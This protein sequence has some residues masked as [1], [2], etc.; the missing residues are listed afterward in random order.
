MKRILHTFLNYFYRL[1]YR[2]LYLYR[3]I[4]IAK[5]V[6]FDRNTTFK[7]NIKIY[8]NV[9]IKNASIGTGTYI[10]WDSNY[11]G[12]VIGNFCSIAP[13]SQ[14]IFGKHPSKQFITT[15]PAFFSLQKQAGFTFV[16]ESIFTEN[17]FA[18]V[19]RRKSVVIG[20]DVWIGNGASIM[21]GVT[22]GDGAIVAA[23]ALVTKN[24]EPY[25]IVAGVPAK[26]IDYRFNKDEIVR[27]MSLDIWNRDFEWIKNHAALFNDISHLDELLQ[28]M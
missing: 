27:L 2:K 26:I 21:E 11:T 22:I 4:F 19:Q 28:K 8:K 9:H 14:V 15:H 24:V 1:L 5:N 20:N 3:D 7:S 23:G 25:S 17:T 12:C 6:E 13:H 10:G 18:D 16:E